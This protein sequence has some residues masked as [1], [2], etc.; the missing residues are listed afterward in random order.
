MCFSPYLQGYSIPGMLWQ[1]DFRL[2]VVL[3]IRRRTVVRRTRAPGGGRKPQ[4][5][6]T[7][8]KG[9]FSM[10]ISEEL[11]ARLKREADRSGRAL[12]QEV[13]DR[14]RKSLVERDWTKKLYGPP[15][16]KALGE[17]VSVLA[18]RIEQTTNSNWRESP[19]A[20]EAL[21]I[22]TERI[23]LG[24]APPKWTRDGSYEIPEAIEK[25]AENLAR[26]WPEEVDQERKPEGVAS[27]I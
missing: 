10:R 25:R 22:A 5:E 4:G 20:F 18:R 7:N 15:H 6:Y 11:R 8:R 27:R 26:H 14:L 9:Q 13:E 23:L 17:D 3:Q 19:F 21:R 24:Y 12:S 2:A 16:N 1:K